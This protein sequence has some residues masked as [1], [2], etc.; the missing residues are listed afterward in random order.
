MKSLIPLEGLY[1]RP[2]YK[3]YRKDKPIGSTFINGVVT[4][5]LKKADGHNK[6]RIVRS[7]MNGFTI[8]GVVYRTEITNPVFGEDAP[9]SDYVTG[10]CLFIQ[11]EDTLIVV[12]ARTSSFEKELVDRV[13]PYAYADLLEKMQ[14][15]CTTYLRTSAKSMNLGAGGP[16]RQ[17]RE[18]DRLELVVS[19]FGLNRQMLSQVKF[20]LRSGRSVSVTP[21]SNTI[22]LYGQALTIGD[23]LRDCQYICVCLA[24]EVDERQT[25]FVRQ[26]AAPVRISELPDDV[27]PTLITVLWQ[28]IEEAIQTGEIRHLIRCK[29]GAEP[30]QVPLSFVSKFLRR[31]AGRYEIGHDDKG[32]SLDG[33]GKVRLK[34]NL[35]SDT[36][37][38]NNPRLSSLKFVLSDGRE[39]SVPAYINSQSLSIVW[40]SDPSYVYSGRTLYRDHK[41]TRSYEQ[42]LSIFEAL[43]AFD[44]V[45]SEKGDSHTAQQTEFDDDCLFGAITVHFQDQSCVQACDDLATEYCDI[46]VYGEEE[47]FYI[48]AKHLRKKETDGTYKHDSTFSASSLQDVTGQCLKNLGLMQDFDA[49]QDRYERKW[50][51]PWNKT[52]VPRIRECGGMCWDDV[53]ATAKDINTKKVAALAISS[54]SLSKLKAGI[55]AVCSEEGPQDVEHRRRATEIGQIIWFLWSFI[56]S[57][58]EYGFVPRIYC[59][60]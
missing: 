30:R 52:A 1:F 21:N 11:N 9:W 54:M 15:D 51:K 17:V 13:S 49:Q 23:I 2:T 10:Y 26:F 45:I 6:R 42:L 48:H 33:H 20:K 56:H 35:K 59:K 57:C 22:V 29:H 5:I 53:I 24:R 58:R 50:K 28:A 19:A 18:A 47:H 32:Y 36:Y 7:K 8:D 31:T 25:K 38:L 16:R 39:M 12:Q 60:P 55:E 44:S 27:E 43:P 14:Y 3:V 41:L 37:T 46:C 40:F 34:A 4:K